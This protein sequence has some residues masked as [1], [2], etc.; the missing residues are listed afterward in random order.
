M[1]KF[2]I[3]AFAATVALA[4]VTAALAQ[5]HG[6]DH[7]HGDYQR[8]NDWKRGHRLAHDEWS[9]GRQVDWR[10]HHLRRPGRG[11]E[12]REVDGNYVLAAAATGLIVS[13]LAAR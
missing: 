12:W 10:Q 8:H 11:Q 2:V 13:A 4:P 1:K 9:R 5:P 7:R 6:D 3:A